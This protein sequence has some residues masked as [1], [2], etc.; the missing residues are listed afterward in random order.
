[1]SDA[2]TP[3]L[4]PSPDALPFWQAANRHELR[5]PYCLECRAFFF[6][7]RPR[8]PRCGAGPVDW[9]RCSGRGRVYTYCIQYQ[10]AVPG[11]EQAVPFV[12]AIIEL[13]EGPR[14]MSFLVDVA[15]NP[16]SVRCDMPV[17]VTFISLPDGQNLPVFRPAAGE[18]T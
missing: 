8:C 5:L 17:E 10:T 15:P 16:D 6:Y 14:L 11:L 3:P 18:R 1:M 13:D 4:S 9:R 2:F 7:P 12:T